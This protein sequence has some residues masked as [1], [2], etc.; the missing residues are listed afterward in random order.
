MQNKLSSLIEAT[1]LKEA[2]DCNHCRYPYYENQNATSSQRSSSY[3][4]PKPGAQGG[5][6]SPSSFFRFTDSFA[7]APERGDCKQKGTKISPSQV[8]GPFTGFLPFFAGRMPKSHAP[9]KLRHSRRSKRGL[10][11][12]SLGQGS[13]SILGFTY[14]GAQDLRIL[15]NLP[16]NSRIVGDFWQHSGVRVS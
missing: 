3:L 6:A 8:S 1:R 4:F 2:S 11:C 13:A 14:S 16:L 12:S 9:F 5:P 10:G 7:K 15:F